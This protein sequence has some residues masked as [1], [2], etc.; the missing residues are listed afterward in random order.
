[1]NESEQ[2][3]TCRKANQLTSKSGSVVD[4]GQIQTLPVYGLGGVRCR[5][6][7]IL[8]QA[9]MWNVGTCWF[10]VKE[11]GVALL[12]S[13]ASTNVNQRGGVTRSSDEGAVMVLEQRGYVIQPRLVVNQ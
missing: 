4:P 1:M 5:G 8:F 2:S 6:Y 3:M 7:M 13:S 10:N 12:S 9:L 11:R